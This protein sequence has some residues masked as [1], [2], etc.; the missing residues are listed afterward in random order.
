MTLP[1]LPHKKKYIIEYNVPV[2]G[3]RIVLGTVAI[4]L[5]LALIYHV[6]TG[7]LFFLIIPIP[8][9]IYVFTYCAVEID[10]KKNT[11]NEYIWVCGIEISDKKGK[12]PP[13]HYILVKDTVFTAR[14]R[15][16][17]VTNSTDCYEVALVGQDRFKL[18][19]LYGY[20]KNITI[21]RAL[22]LQEFLGYEIN[23]MTRE[24]IMDNIVE[25]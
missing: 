7:G 23:D 4:L 14:G 12:I 19:V 9:L 5:A 3:I 20:D 1:V 6:G 17:Q 13:I 11:Y 21:K 2:L 24:A 22:E 15:R 18:V 10:L 16:G 25:G 8:I